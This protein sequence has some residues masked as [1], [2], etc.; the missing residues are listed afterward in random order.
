MTPEHSAA[1]RQQILEAARICVL[2]DG[3]H[4]TSMQDIQREAGLSAGAI[5]LYFKSKDDIILGI[6]RESLG[7][8]AS[9]FPDEPVID[10]EVLD[11]PQLMQVFLAEADRL[12]REKQ[13]FSI[14]IQVWAEAIRNPDML[15]HLKVYMTAIKGRL[16]ALL[17]A[18]QA[19]GL[20]RAD[21]DTVGLTMA[22]I[23]VG[24]GFMVQRVLFGETT[25][26]LYAAGVQS[27]LMNAAAVP[28]GSG[29]EHDPASEEA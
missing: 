4:Q 24:Q 29:L 5:Y 9:L 19:R 22:I 12:Q 8:F 27:L 15:D 18:C 28:V 7:T 26:E 21:A 16:Q 20:I 11:L 2:R 1:R 3:F 6:A 25:L 14:A 17:E 23:G 13:V 10:G